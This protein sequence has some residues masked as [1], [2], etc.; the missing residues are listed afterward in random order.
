VSDIQEKY[1]TERTKMML[2]L[3]Q[4]YAAY[5]DE[6]EIMKQNFLYGARVSRFLGDQSRSSFNPIFPRMIYLP[7]ERVRMINLYQSQLR[8]KT[9]SNFFRRDNGLS[10]QLASWMG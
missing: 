10:S 7:H 3:K 1:Q 8:D 6:R 2:K 4:N 5:M 9:K